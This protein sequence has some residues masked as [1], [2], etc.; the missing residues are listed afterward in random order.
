MEARTRQSRW[1]VE[2]FLQ[3]RDKEI[4]RA[5]GRLRFLTTRE[6]TT[7]WFGAAQ[8]ARRRL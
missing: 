6:V 4:L 7:T 5:L 1:M 3:L 2:K 8:V